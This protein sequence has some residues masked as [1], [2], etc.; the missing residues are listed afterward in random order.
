MQPA[1][2]QVFCAKQSPNC[3]SCPLQLQCE[4][5]QNNGKRMQHPEAPPAQAAPAAE[6]ATSQHAAQEGGVQPS[7]AAA[8]SSSLKHEATAAMPATQ[9]LT[10]GALSVPSP[11]QS[12]T[13]FGTLLF[14]CCPEHASIQQGLTSGSHSPA[15]CD[16]YVV[17]FL[18]G[19]HR[20]QRWP[21]KMWP[22]LTWRTCTC[23]PRD[24]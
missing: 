3:A 10:P 14:P 23:A 17:W 21:C 20:R 2:L 16:F 15:I 12:K 22:C 11:L 18:Q 5:A 8:P 9:G 13:C 24:L 7:A 6:A 1:A 19:V 4:Y